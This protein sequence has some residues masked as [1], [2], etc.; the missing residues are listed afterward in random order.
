MPKLFIVL[1]CLTASPLFANA[2]ETRFRAGLSAYS[3]YDTSAN[4]IDQALYVGVGWVSV[5]R[6]LDRLEGLSA[7]TSACDEVANIRAQ[8]DTLEAPLRD[9]LRQFEL[10]EALCFGYNQDR[11]QQNIS[12]LN[13]H[14]VEL[15][16]LNDFVSRLAR[17]CAG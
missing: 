17:S 8:V 15:V 7:L 6:V 14:L 3:R 12:A 13:G 2:C 11:A 5:P 16:D 1:L 9:A 10:S 4:S